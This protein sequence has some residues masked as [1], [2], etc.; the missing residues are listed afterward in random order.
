MLF[1][2][3]AF[4]FGSIMK[5]VRQLAFGY[6]TKCNIRCGHCVAA[7]QVQST[8]KMGIDIARNIIIDMAECG[9]SGISFTAGEPLLFLDDI[10]SLVQIC[11]DLGIYSR[12]VTNGYWAKSKIHADKIVSQL[13]L[14]GLSQLRISCSRWHQEHIKFNNIITAATSCE[15]NGLDYFVS[16][17]TDFSKQ[18]NSI[19]QSLQDN[20]LRYFPEPVIYFGKAEVLNRK[21][22]FTDF[23]PN[24]CPMNPYLTPE[25]DMY[26]CCDGAGRFS[27]TKFLH[28][29][30]LRNHSID[31]LFNKKEN[32]IFYNLIRTYGLSII[33]SRLGI[34]AND[35]VK[36]RKCEL[37]ELIF[38]SKENLREV[39]KTVLE[40]LK[41]WSR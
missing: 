11:K 3:D 30:N 21:K 10:C 18:D 23:S 19:E 35:I 17:I 9:V 37:C 1:F 38:N 33:A 28:L 7:G 4:F 6:S 41:N 8:S 13:I 34:K 16:F 5:P 29:G 31:D 25:L 2:L 26:A 22:I 15:N 24:I 20:R 32:N 36:Y 12:V 14:N 27:K 40:K 39:N